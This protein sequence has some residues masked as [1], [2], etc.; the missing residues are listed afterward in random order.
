MDSALI[1]G[2]VSSVVGLLG[3]GGGVFAFITSRQKAK[4][5][6]HTSSITEWKQLYDEMK[7]RLDCQ[8]QENQKLREEIFELRNQLNELTLELASYKKYDGY[9]KDL[10]VYID[11]VLHTL[12]PLT[13][14]DAYKT[15]KVKRP[16]KPISTVQDAK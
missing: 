7:E 12:K 4:V 13:S 9:I 5:Q 10:E 15:L 14:E 16:Q 1:L 11:M 8:E 2:I 6:L 3:G